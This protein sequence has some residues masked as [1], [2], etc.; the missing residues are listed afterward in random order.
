MLRALK[1]MQTAAH[2]IFVSHAVRNSALELG[3]VGASKSSVIPMGVHPSCTACPN[4]IADRTAE[5]Y[6]SKIGGRHPILLHVGSTV[7]RKRLDIV[8]QV[9]AEVSRTLPDAILVRVGGQLTEEQRRLALTIGVNHRVLE[10]PYLE[11]NVLAAI[12]RR[13]NVVLQPSEAEGF[14]LPVVEAMACGCPVIASDLEVLREVGGTAAVYC[15]V[16]DVD[17][18]TREVLRLLRSTRSHSRSSDERQRSIA[19]QASKFSWIETTKRVVQVY[20]QVIA[21]RGMNTL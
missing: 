18:W 20:E 13:A 10:L 15:P 21:K 16:G 4:D 7:R 9:L 2:T 19:E 12:Y 8:L 5:K 3:I 1:G 14:G 17:Y 6:L 11:R